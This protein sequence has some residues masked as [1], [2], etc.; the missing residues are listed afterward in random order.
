MAFYI[1]SKTG[2]D[3]NDG[4]TLASAFKSMQHAMH[5]AQSGDALV[6]AP[7]IYENDLDKRIGAARSLGVTVTAAGTEG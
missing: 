4:R 5:V 3:T 1:N 2:S 6:I 7:G